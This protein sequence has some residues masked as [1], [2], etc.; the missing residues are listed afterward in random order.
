MK[1]I[2]INKYLSYIGSILFCLLLLSS[3][4]VSALSGSQ[5]V[6]GRIIDDFVFT[7]KNS[8]SVADIQNF[9][10]SKVPV[11]DYNGIQ[12]SS[13]WNSSAGRYYTRAEWGALNGEPAP[14]V[15]LKD[16]YENPDTKV[17]NLHF[18]T[19]PGGGKSAAQLIWDV[20]QQYNISPKVLIV[21]LQKEQS[22][23]TDDWPWTVQYRSATGYGCPDTAPCASQYYGFYNQ[24][25][26]AAWQ[27]NYYATHPTSFNYRA[28]FDNYIQ[29]SPNASCGGSTVFIQ[30]QAT[31]SLYIYT[32]Y[33][34]NAA[35]LNNLYG[36]G[37]ACSAYGNRNFW[38]M[39]NDWFGTTF[40]DDTNTP[41]PNGTLV[42]D[43]MG[44]Y[45]VNGGTRQWIRSPAVFESY[46]YDWN[47]IKKAS[48]GDLALPLGSNIDT[49]APG[50]VFST[51]A[52]PT[53]IMDYD[54]DGALKKRLISNYALKELGY[55]GADVKYVPAS[56]VPAATFDSPLNTLV[57]P[58][59]AIITFFGI[60]T[61][62]VVDQG[63]LRPI[64]NELAFEGNGY[65]MSQIKGGT[66]FD[67]WLP[68]G[69]VLQSRPGV[70]VNDGQGIV[71]IDFDSSGIMKRPVGPWDCYADRLHYSWT[72]WYSGYLALRLPARTGPI[73]TC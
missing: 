32:P 50:T 64:E 49:L 67:S 4:K 29:Y 55:T 7:N 10:N 1:K 61:V 52:S 2:G 13:H 20:S 60:P 47:R 35:A 5:F 14:F 18:A 54:T 57:H 37:D 53:Y 16:Y 26:N 68:R 38:R 12:N 25:S 9:L 23:I 28:G 58:S 42:T 62:F 36:T 24:I 45:V 56:D 31:A 8:M 19:I 11:C 22:L 17:S 63:Q 65:K 66:Q 44:V 27:F 71:V 69:A 30:N 39:Y 33:Q 3:V 43:G 40:A 72:D 34:P 73:F 15:C 70:I 46:R 21:L 6:A 59:G 41:H 51:G 48:S